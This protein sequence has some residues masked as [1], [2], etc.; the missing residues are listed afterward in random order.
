MRKATLYI[1]TIVFSLLV[2]ACANYDDSVQV[3]D[4]HKEQ[5]IILKNTHKPGYVYSI[6]ISGSGNLDGEASISLILN[7]EPYKTQALKDVVD[8]EWSGDWYADQ[9]EIRYKPVNINSGTL[10][11]RYR[12]LT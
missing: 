7:G 6:H 3:A 11:I 2:T 5:T 4:V 10:V 12:F 9:A 1:G 8:F